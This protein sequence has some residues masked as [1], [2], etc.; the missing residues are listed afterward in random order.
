MA[1]KTLSAIFLFTVTALLI[2]ARFDLDW[3]GG[4]GYDTAQPI[5]VTAKRGAAA[6]DRA[7]MKRAA[8]PGE[9]IARGEFVRTGDDG[10]LMI[11]IAGVATLGLAERT[12]LKIQKFETGRITLFLKRGR[13]MAKMAG[14]DSKLTIATKHTQTTLIAGAAALTNYDFKE[15]VE[16]APLNTTAAVVI[17]EARAFLTE[18]PTAI[19][20][21]DPIMVTDGQFDPAASAGA[22]FYRWFEQ[23]AN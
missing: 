22:D 8:V 9:R 12:D 4:E 23:N 15:T 6:I 7:G 21:T 5:T 10:W 19:H 18:K 3:A 20:E 14:G 2:G 16:I 13:L 17:D 11:E 1:D